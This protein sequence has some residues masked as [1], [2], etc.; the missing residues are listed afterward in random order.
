VITTVIPAG[1]NDEAY[2]QANPDVRNVIEQGGSAP[3]LTGYDHYIRYGIIEG[4][5]GAWTSGRSTA[6]LNTDLRSLARLS[7]KVGLPGWAVEEIVAQ[8]AFA[9]S[10]DP[11]QNLTLPIYD[12]FNKDPWGQSLREL[13]RDLRHENYDHLFFLPWIKRGGADLASILHIQAAAESSSKIAIILTEPG[14][15]DWV[16]RLPSAAEVLFF[17]QKLGSVPIEYQVLACYHLIVALRPTKLHIINSAPAWKLLTD[18][19][20]VLAELTQ[21]YVSLYCYDYSNSGE[22]IGY[23]RMVRQCAPYISRIFTDNTSFRCHLLDDVGI[24]PEKVVVLRHPVLHKVSLAPPAPHSRR[25]LWA[26]RLDRQKRPDLLVQIA[27]RLPSLTFVVYGSAVLE[28]CDEVVR[29]FNAAPNIE[30]SGE[31]DSISQILSPEFRLFLYTSAWDGLPN[32]ILEIMEAGMLVVAGAIGGIGSDLGSD[33]C[34]LVSDHENPDAY[35]T[36]IKMAYESIDEAEATRLRAQA[37]V[38]E[39]HTFEG[40]VRDLQSVGYIA[41]PRAQLA[42][43]AGKLSPSAGTAAGSPTRSQTELTKS[44][45]EPARETEV[46]TAEQHENSAEARQRRINRPRAGAPA[47]REM[48]G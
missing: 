12:P 15:S 32:V 14:E 9:P 47:E 8:S 38:R 42:E 46:G 37:L 16:E 3:L 45:A 4:R 23:A 35:V 29:A 33:N 41:A 30:Y 39:R 48:V 19:P 43:T 22:P 26:S 13:C 40:F 28:Q 44:I 11:V 17:G 2:L 36:A 24:S 34:L 25:I 20:K 21:V 31:F 6:S 7:E 1:W 10:L 27:Q 5:L 18:S